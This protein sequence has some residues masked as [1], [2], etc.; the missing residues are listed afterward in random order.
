METAQGNFTPESVMLTVSLELACAAWKLGLHD[1]RH[2]KVSVHNAD[3]E[4][5]AERLEQAVE[6]VKAQARKWG[7]PDQ[8]RIVFVYEAGQDGFW[9][10]RALT[11][12]GYEAYVVDPASIPV[13]RQARRAKTDR[14]D[15]IRLVECLRAWLRGELAEVRMVHVP[16][17]EAEAQR[18]WARERGV[19]QKEIGQHLDRIGKL[20]RTQGCWDAVGEDFAER[21]RQGLVLRYDG[22]PIPVEMR[23]R[24]LREWERLVFIQGQWKELERSLKQ[25]PEPVRERI[26]HLKRLKA[27]GH[28]GATRLVLEFFWRDFSNRRQVGSCIGLTPQPYD[29][30]DS[31]VDQGISKSGNARVRALAIEM[32]WFWLK[33]QPGSELAQWFRQRTEGSGASKRARRVAI[34][35]IARKLMISLWRYLEHGVIPAGAQLKEV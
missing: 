1:G 8:T 14:L 6:I 30:G 12:K 5:P 3:A 11:G 7:L 15:A 22:K 9:I 20:L 13:K 4:F 17:E 24:L 32:A 26:A 10:Q 19:L 2:P 35:A 31:H 29:S 18:H 25:L 21:L 28:V 27:V 23:T 33:Y 16:S 34:V